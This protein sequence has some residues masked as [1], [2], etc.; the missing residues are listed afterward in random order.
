MEENTTHLSFA[1][2]LAE[3]LTCRHKSG[4]VLYP[5][6]REASIKDVIE[7]VGIPHTEVYSIRIDDREYDF[8]LRL[9]SGLH[10]NILPANLTQNYPV[11]VTRTTLLRPALETL[12]FIVDENVAGLAPM[13]RSLGFDT[14]YHRDWNDAYIARIA[15]TE[16]RTVLSRDRGLLKRKSI[17]H[18]RLIRSQNVDKQILEVL[19]HF[20]IPADMP[21][22]SRCLRCNVITT[23]VEK[24]EILH[25][26]KPKT[27]IHYHSFRRC[28]ACG[29]I[30]W[31]GSHIEKLM[32]RFKALGI[33]I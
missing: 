12:R 21:P 16:G 4:E 13:M 29:R 17:E 5:A 22:F 27:R 3:L 14:A 6:N 33:N 30:Y 11:D 28:P 7:S 19:N 25:L 2:E 9:S 32:S 18:G 20:M 31:R 23:P 1:G 26:L 10:L 24:D 8:S 15:E